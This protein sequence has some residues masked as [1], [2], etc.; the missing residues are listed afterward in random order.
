MIGI[1]IKSIILVILSCGLG[2]LGA[3]FILKTLTKEN[4]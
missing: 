1:V 2:S 3:I 4:K